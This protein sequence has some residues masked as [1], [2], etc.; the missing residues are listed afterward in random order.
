MKI[1]S[2]WR[3]LKSA[4]FYRIVAADSRTAHAMAASSKSWHIHPLWRKIAKERCKN[5]RRARFN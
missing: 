3:L 5:G 1:L 4:L 2:P